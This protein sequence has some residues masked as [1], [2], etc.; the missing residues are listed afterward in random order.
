[1][2]K[3]VGILGGMGPEATADL[4]LKI[5]RK[6]PAEKDQEHIRIIMDNNPKIPGRTAYITGNGESPF[7]FLVETAKKL[8]KYGADFLVMPCN[9]AHYF[10]KDIVKTIS[11]PMINMIEET[12]KAVD[13]KEYNNE[14]G[15]CVLCTLGAKKS[16]IYEKCFKEHGI[17]VLLPDERQQ[18]VVGEAIYDYKA[19][20]SK[21]AVNKMYRICEDLKSG[22]IKSL[23]LGC[24]EL[25][26]ILAGIRCD[27]NIYDPTDIL[28]EKA[29]KFALTGV[30]E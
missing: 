19:G 11:I 16:G 17:E 5:I 27:F 22:G 4:F 8:E 21:E 10:Y 13:L 20:K 1:M 15:I 2:E 25:P 14:G 9:T 29:V 6:T 12:V 24:T 30:L 26:V 18:A 28:A 7:P 23:V 3:I